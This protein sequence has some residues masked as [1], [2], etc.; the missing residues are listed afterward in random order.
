[1]SCF[2]TKTHI[3]AFINQI[4]SF[5]HYSLFSVSLSSIS[6]KSCIPIHIS[7]IFTHFN[8]NLN[9]SCIAIFIF[10]PKQR[11]QIILHFSCKAHRHL[12]VW[13]ART[14]RPSV[15]VVN[16]TKSCGTPHDLN[17]LPSVA[18]I[19]TFKLSETG[20]LSHDISSL[21]CNGQPSRPQNLFTRTPSSTRALARGWCFGDLNEIEPNFK[22]FGALSCVS[23]CVM[24]TDL[25]CARLH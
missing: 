20:R 24:R 1:M 2:S 25:R 16:S 3:S 13:F 14:L 10:Q 6:C 9:I 15:Y 19:T 17:E 12:S 4:Q 21:L 22:N 5:V 11:I 7:S 8:I 23:L 18:S